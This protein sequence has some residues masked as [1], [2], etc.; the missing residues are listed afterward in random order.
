MGLWRPDVD[1]QR[2]PT[3]YGLKHGLSLKLQLTGLAKPAGQQAL[4]TLLFSY[5]RAGS[6]GK[7]CHTWGFSFS[8]FKRKRACWASR[9]AQ[10]GKALAPDSAALAAHIRW[11][12]PGSTELPSDLH[13]CAVACTFPHT[14]PT[15]E[16]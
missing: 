10:Q 8:D 15:K 6:M 16:Y 11:K 4:E 2:F 12:R 5:L 1:V 3:A 9:M 7:E 14:R 13:M